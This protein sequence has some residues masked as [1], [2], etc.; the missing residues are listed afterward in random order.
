MT[1]VRTFPLPPDLRLAGDFKP[2]DN[3]MH[4]FVDL[5]E[6]KRFQYPW[7]TPDLCIYRDHQPEDLWDAMADTGVKD[8]VFVQCLNDSPEE[9]KWVMSLAKQHPRIKGIV[10]GLDPSHPQFESRLVALKE[11]VPLLVGFRHILDIDPR[12]DYLEREELAAGVNLLHKY[13]MTFDLLLRPP[14]LEGAGVLA[15]RVSGTRMVVDHLAKPYIAEGK[16]DPWRE[17]IAAV[18]R[19]PNIYCKLSSM[20]TEADLE[21]WKDLRPYVEASG[22]GEG[23]GGCVAIY[24]DVDAGVCGVVG[25]NDFGGGV[26]GSEGGD[27]MLKV[28]GPDRL[29]FGSDWPVCRLAANTDYGRVF[30]ALKELLQH[31]PDHQQKKIFCTNARNFYNIQ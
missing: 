29:M 14:L 4:D 23:K 3:I 12:Q 9:A 16:L 22:V 7:P 2:V 20:A 21:K 11:E 13:N 26:G 31:L 28:F 17:H 18:A 19:Y 25:R 1:Q 10:A 15:S 24:E 30:S 8:V 5:F 27:H 6:L